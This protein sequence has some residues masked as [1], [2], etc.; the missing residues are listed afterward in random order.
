[1]RRI[2]ILL[3]PIRSYLTRLRSTL[4][5]GW[6]DFWFMPTDPATLSLIRICAG[7][8]VLYIF[9]SCASERLNLIGPHGWVDSQAV[10]ELQSLGGD[11]TS[12]S[13]AVQGR[14]WGQSVWNHA[15]SDTVAS[16]LYWYLIAAAVC[17]TIGFFSRT[18]N[19]FVLIGHLSFLHRSYVAWFG[20]DSILAMI[21]LYMLVGPTGAAYS[22]DSLLRRRKARKSGDTDAPETVPR[23]YWQANLAVRMIQIHM[24]VIYLCSGLTKLQ[25]E[26]WWDGTAVLRSLMGYELALVDLRWLGW[27]SDTTLEWFST[28]SV[29]ATLIFEIGFAFLIWKQ[30]LRPIMLAGAVFLHLGIAVSMGLIGFG[31]IMMTG[32]IAF[33][34]P[35]SI[36]W[37]V[38]VLSGSVNDIGDQ[39][40]TDAAIA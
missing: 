3:Q 15:R 27:F 38:Q 30:L 5:Q 2:R 21:L 39:S 22:V 35:E 1:M 18:S 25:G 14:W 20:M 6:S 24:C 28:L 31:A 29:A 23:K 4:T 32:C 11:E 36:R 16:V 34:A 12:R 17:M 40:L 9:V 26:T 10:S 19:F 37:V 8:V 13:G 7:L 33:V